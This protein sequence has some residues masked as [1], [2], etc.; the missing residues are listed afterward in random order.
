MFWLLSPCAIAQNS[1]TQ[2]PFKD[3]LRNLPLNLRGV[4]KCQH[5][6]KRLFPDTQHHIER[7]YD[8]GQEQD[9]S[10]TLWDCRGVGVRVEEGGE[11]REK[12]SV[13]V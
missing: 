8:G 11:R 2:S 5:I 13:V 10:D 6:S 4:S 7:S 1:E 9:Y 3:F 12:G